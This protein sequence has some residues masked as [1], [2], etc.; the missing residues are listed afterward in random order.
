MDKKM[1]KIIGIVVGIFIF[2]IIILFVI[3]SC[4]KKKLDVW[5]H[6]KSFRVLSSEA[7]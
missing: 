7:C 1:V 4:S 2:L 5:L 6:K 3:S